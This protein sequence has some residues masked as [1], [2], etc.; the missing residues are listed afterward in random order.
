VKEARMEHRQM[1]GKNFQ[2]EYRPYRGGRHWRAVEGATLRI[3]SSKINIRG[4]EIGM[5]EE[6]DFMGETLWSAME[7]EG[8]GKSTKI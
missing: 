2:E 4:T 6:E 3:D 1:K 8:S 7:T 5:R